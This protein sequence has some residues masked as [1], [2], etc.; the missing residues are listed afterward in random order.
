MGHSPT[1]RWPNVADQTIDTASGA[2]AFVD[3]FDL[4]RFLLVQSE[5]HLCVLFIC[6][7]SGDILRADH[8]CRKNSGPVSPF[9]RL[10]GRDRLIRENR[11]ILPLD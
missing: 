4:W 7:G 6:N 11:E 9:R 5:E 3:S 8:H 1:Q 10:S 2:F